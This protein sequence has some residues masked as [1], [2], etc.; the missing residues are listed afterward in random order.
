MKLE[1]PVTQKDVTVSRFEM[2]IQNDPTAESLFCSEVYDR[3]N[4]DNSVVATSSNGITQKK[5]AD[6]MQGT[7]EMTVAHSLSTE[8]IYAAE[9]Y[10]ILTDIETTN[11]GVAYYVRTNGSATTYRETVKLSD[12]PM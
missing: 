8:S 11:N 10:R 6:G 2:S 4:E 1:K 7:I 9:L 12:L 5:T 3:V